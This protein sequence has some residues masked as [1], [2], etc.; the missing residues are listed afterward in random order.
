M[1]KGGSGGGGG[2]EDPRINLYTHSFDFVMETVGIAV[3][4]RD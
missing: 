1:T 3:H 2:W 4:Y